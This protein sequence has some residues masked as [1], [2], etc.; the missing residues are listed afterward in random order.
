M[1]LVAIKF[2]SN[3]N[4]NK[5]PFQG[6][7][8]QDK[9]CCLI[10]HRKILINNNYFK[11]FEN[12][13]ILANFDVKIYQEEISDKTSDLRRISEEVRRKEESIKFNNTQIE[14]ASSKFENINAQYVDLLTKVQEDNIEMIKEKE[15]Y[16]V[17]LD[18]LQNNIREINKESF[19]VEL[20]LDK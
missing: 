13:L 17:E 9:I 11:K 3:V 2:E 18:K 5:L 15:G 12:L 14:I 20:D 1:L 16:L 7:Q 6:K 10:C 4:S 8:D 19:S